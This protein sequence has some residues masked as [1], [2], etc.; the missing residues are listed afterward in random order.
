FRRLSTDLP[1]D[2][3]YPADLKELGFKQ[4][5]DGHFVNI[6]T[7]EYFAY[8][9]TNNDRANEVRREA[10]TQCIRSA[11]FEALKE[12]DIK[13]LYCH[14]DTYSETADGPAVPILTTSRQSLKAKREVVMLVGE[15]NH[16]LGIFAYR[17]L[18]NEGGME[19]GS[20]IGL[21]KQLQTLARPPGVIIFNPGQLL[22]SHKEKQAMSQTSWLARNKE[23]ALHEHY[24]I[25]PV[26]NYVTGHTTPNEHVATV[27]KYVVPEITHEG[28]K[29]YTIA[30][31]D[32]CEN[33][34]KAIDV[35]LEE[36]SDAW[37]GGAVEAFALMQTTH[38]PHEIKNAALRMFLNLRGRGWVT[39]LDVP[40]GKL[41][42]LP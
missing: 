19:E 2:P 1:K 5:D 12:F 41:I 8:R 14:G 9:H 29:L 17:L 16:D 27:L 21:L 26:H 20:V 38:R 40:P 31:S 4:T 28:A 34:L 32:G 15:Y 6:E 42:A 33:M 10:M 22:Y 30:I 25:H 23:S 3:V 18:M 36:D 7:G 11:V 39:A 35:Q 37:I 24:R 13:P